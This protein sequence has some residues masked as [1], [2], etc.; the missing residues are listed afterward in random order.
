M[1]VV[2]WSLSASAN[3]WMDRETLTRLST[4]PV[5]GLLE[6]DWDLGSYAM[7]SRILKP[8]L[9]FGLLES[10]TESSVANRLIDRHLYRKTALFDRFVKFN[11]QV[12]RPATQH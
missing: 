10:R 8:L 3:E 12:E 1:G 11:V 5:V 7:E 9:W 6:S 2:L 4:I